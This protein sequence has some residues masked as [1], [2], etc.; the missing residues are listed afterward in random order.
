MIILKKLL[1][2]EVGELPAPN[3]MSS[4]DIYNF[5]FLWWVA[6]NDPNLVATPFGKEVMNHYLN[7]LQEKYVRLFK[8]ILAK[9]IAKYIQRGR[10]D[11]DFPKDA[12]PQLQGMSVSQL[13]ALM[14][15]TFRSDMQRRN[16]VW[17]LA[18]G[19]VSKLENAGGTKDK[20][21]Y[22]N[23]LNN[24]VHNTGSQIMD[25]F[26]NFYSELKPAF[27][28]VHRATNPRLEFK[29]FVDKDI[30][31]LL[32]QDI[33]SGGEPTDMYYERIMMNEGLEKIL[34]IR[35]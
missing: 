29:P 10:V 31:N 12:L 32:T 24:V 17:D 33:A 13:Q 19:F 14:A 5:Y 11:P 21:L 15:K 8:A 20:F 34:R 28:R 25:K 35:K 2:K 22:I 4:K 1:L 7:K 16:D 6:T 9:Q 18:A 27:D 23:Q 3:T 30:R 26:P